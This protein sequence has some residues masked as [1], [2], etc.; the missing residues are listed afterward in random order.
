MSLGHS[1]NGYLN[2]GKDLTISVG[3]AAPNT[4]PAIRTDQSAIA[5]NQIDLENGVPT[6]TPK[7]VPGGETVSNGWLSYGGKFTVAAG[8]II[9]MTCGSGGFTFQTSGPMDFNTAGFNV[10][11]NFIKIKSETFELGSV[12]TMVRGKRF[13]V[14]TEETSF[15]NQ[16]TFNNN[17]VIKGG[18]YVAGETYNSHSTTTTQQNLTGTCDPMGTYVNCAQSFMLYQ[19]ISKAADMSIAKKYEFKP[20]Q[21]RLKSSFG[22]IDALL[23][24]EIPG[25]ESN[26]PTPLPIKIAFPYGISMVSDSG[27]TMLKLED[28]IKLALNPG[29]ILNTEMSDTMGAPHFHTYVGSGSV[30]GTEALTNAAAGCATNNPIQA[31]Q[32][33]LGG[34]KNFQEAEQHIKKT[35]TECINKQKEEFQKFIL[36]CTPS[37]K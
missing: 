10:M 7:K 3:M 6:V 37:A 29:R 26:P 15:Q 32:S 9:S 27:L 34:A 25:I 12:T 28:V 13:I 1:G 4:N 35:I 18:L 2:Y 36:M 24:A 8:N 11:A 5:Y 14:D 17:V 33:L 21:N 22:F 31:Q 16:V 19:G 20:V 30:N 23:Y